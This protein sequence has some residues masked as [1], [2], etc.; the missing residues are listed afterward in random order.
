VIPLPSPYL[1]SA[2]PGL[3]S[4]TCQ[5]EFPR[6]VL[7]Y[8]FLTVLL[9]SAWLSQDWCMLKHA[10]VILFLSLSILAWKIPWMEEPGRLKSIWGRWGSDTTEWLHFHFSRS[11]IGEGNGNPL[12]CLAWRIPGTGEPGG[13]PS[14]GSHRVGHDWTDLAAAAAAVFQCSQ[15][16]ASLTQWTWVWANSRRWWRTGCQVCCS[17]W[18]FKELT[19]T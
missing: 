18:L 1:F 17:L 11:C 13:L 19:T 9:H 14:M 16:V 5:Y 12:Q 4:V 3:L 2:A 15:W 6:V 10:S 8:L 7:M